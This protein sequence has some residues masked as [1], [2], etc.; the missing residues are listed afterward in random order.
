MGARRPALNIPPDLPN[1][2]TAALRY[3]SSDSEI[4][5]P[6]LSPNLCPR[7]ANTLFSIVDKLVGSKGL[8]IKARR[9]GRERTKGLL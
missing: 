1:P 5:Q 2:P 8:E 7:L 3:L 9:E 6:F 4:R